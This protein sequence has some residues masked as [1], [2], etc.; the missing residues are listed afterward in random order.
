[1]E[2]KAQTA[3]KRVMAFIAKWTDTFQVSAKSLKMRIL[4]DFVFEIWLLVKAGGLNVLDDWVG[5]KETYGLSPLDGS[6]DAS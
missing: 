3:E 4:L 5:Q 2:S 6:S 1:M